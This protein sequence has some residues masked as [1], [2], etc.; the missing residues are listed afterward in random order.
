M[1]IND[2]SN[3]SLSIKKPV[4]LGGACA[5]LAALTACNQSTT[6]EH[7]QASMPAESIQHA[8][9]AAAYGN[10]II[11]SNFSARYIEREQR[12]T[13]QTFEARSNRL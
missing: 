3:I 9:S 8:R 4:L 6:Y 2:Q 5:V 13:Y 11:Q 10:S 1:Q 12:E 7:A